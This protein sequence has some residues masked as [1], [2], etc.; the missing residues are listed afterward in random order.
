MA[1]PHYKFTELA[2]TSAP[3]VVG[4]VNKALL[5]IDAAIYENAGGAGINSIAP[6]TVAYPPYTGSDVSIAI[7]NNASAQGL[8]GI[9]IG[10]ESHAVGEYSTCVGYDAVCTGENSL[11]LGTISYAAGN[12]SVAFPYTNAEEDNVFAVGNA[13]VRTRR[14]IGASDP[15]DAQDAATRNYVINVIRD[16][17]AKN[18]LTLPDWG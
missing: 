12:Y 3:D 18:N 17:C 4:D 1:T 8:G 10:R 14:I 7:G 2:N 16:L 6:T 5:E 9:A 15:V 11:A 13:G